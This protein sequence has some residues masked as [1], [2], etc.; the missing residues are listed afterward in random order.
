MTLSK[1]IYSIERSTNILIL[2]FKIT[3]TKHK[4]DALLL[5]VS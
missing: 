1:S 2:I 5:T 3:N 4:L